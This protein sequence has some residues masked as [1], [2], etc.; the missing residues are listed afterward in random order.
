M[1]KDGAFHPSDF[2]KW[3]GCDK[4]Y[5]LEVMNA[6]PPRSRSPKAINGSAIHY[7][8]E[9]MHTGTNG[10]RDD[11]LDD[12]YAAAFR[13]AVDEPV[14]DAERGV[15]ID[16]GDFM[17]AD[18]ARAHYASEA[19]GMLRGYAADPRN[20][21]ATVI[22][23]HH[24]W[25]ATI[26]GAPWSGEIDRI[27]GNADGTVTICDFKSGTKLSAVPLKMWHQIV[28][29]IGLLEATGLNASIMRWIALPDYVPYLRSGKTKDGREYKRGQ[30]RGIAYYDV[31]ITK[32]VVDAMRSEMRM[33]VD[34]VRSGRFPRRPSNDMC[35]RCR[36]SDVCLAGFRASIVGIDPS[37]VP[38]NGGDDV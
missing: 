33:F 8:L 14:N 25:K 30:T 13:R 10:F 29:A 28:Y 4:R 20:R 2:E 7:V 23:V 3:R 37:L 21:N 18:H 16:W 6:H 34:S 35:G 26:D 1:R 32:D 31:T 36:V 19:L 12:V 11:S 5:E 24:K 15:P 27:D 22:A 38:T 9:W 17:D